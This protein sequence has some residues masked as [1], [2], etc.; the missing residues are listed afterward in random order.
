MSNEKKYL[1]N[2]L[3][4]IILIYSLLTILFFAP[5]LKSFA[6]ELIGPPEDNM[7][8]FWNMWWANKVFFQQEGSLAFSKY[9][10]YPE[11]GSLLFQAYS[12]YN[13]FLS[14]V[15]T[16]F[17]SLVTVYNLLI[18]STFVLSGLGAYLL[19]RY[20]TDDSDISLIGGLIFAF[21]PSHFAHSLHHIEISSIQFIPF[22]VLF[23]IKALRSNSRRDTFLAC[24]F[25]ALNGLCSLY[26]F[27]LGIYFMVFSYVYLIWKKKQ[28]ILPEALAKIGLIIGS[29][30]TIL[31]PWLFRMITL[32]FKHPD[33]TASSRM[34]VFVVDLFALFTPHPNHIFAGLPI[35]EY[36][37]NTFTG[38]SWEF[39]AYLGMVN[40]VLIAFTFKGI[41]KNTAKYFLAAFLFIVL[42][43]GTYV[44]VLG[45]QTSIALPYAIIKHVPL[46]SS[47]RTPSRAIV[48]AYLFLAIIVSCAIKYAYNSFNFKVKTKRFFL[49][50]ITVLIFFDYFSV[51]NNKT[52]V[53]CPPVYSK[54]KNEKS[55]FGVLNLPVNDYTDMA[56]YMMYQT[57]HEI[58]IVEGYIA[59]KI[60]KSLL[61][62]LEFR[63]LVKQQKQLVN[64][65]IKY[66]LIHKDL[67]KK[68][69]LRDS[70]INAYMIQYK[71]VY[72]DYRN[73]IF[74]VY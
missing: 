22:F 65:S 32:S 40:I 10:F 26:Y 19:I 33:V 47:M 69:F 2:N 7:V 42:S 18:L 17:F 61:D 50:L 52:K 36:I 25:F 70:S 63:D 53:Y 68:K 3:S 28:I 27:I 30:V 23:F 38:F 11:G 66:I 15:L 60:D 57:I 16:K 37:N 72:E 67:F 31:S 14:T 73:I 21:N 29:T 51:C 49:L 46:L 6:T 48:F 41:I 43:M 20:L 64:N 56:R 35:V 55:D 44:H 4:A 12:F 62:Y 58:P 59:R 5:C 54:I 8:H 1:K 34:D 13:I 24:L 45:R 71:K 9:I 39:T 74:Q